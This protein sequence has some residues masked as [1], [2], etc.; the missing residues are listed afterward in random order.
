[1]TPSK[2]SS[3]VT[4][5]T[6]KVLICLCYFPHPPPHNYTASKNVRGCAYRGHCMLQETGNVGKLVTSLNDLQKSHGT[7]RR[8]DCCL[9]MCVILTKPHRPVF[10][11]QVL[12]GFLSSQVYLAPE[13]QS[14]VVNSLQTK[15]KMYRA[16]G[17]L[18]RLTVGLRLR[19]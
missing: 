18:S 4:P 11:N 3:F 13:T 5:N 9:C 12:N 6:A 2:N 17:R 8:G 7:L 15:S 1:M 19:S 14:Q 16:P 10:I